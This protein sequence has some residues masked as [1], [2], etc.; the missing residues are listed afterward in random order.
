MSEKIVAELKSEAIDEYRAIPFWSWNDELEEKKLVK[1]IEWMK[2]AGFGGYFMHARGGLK[3]EYMGEKW[4]SCIKACVKAGKRLKMESW[5]YD[6]NGWPSGFAGGKLLENPDYRDRYLTRERGDFDETAYASYLITKD[7]LIRVKTRTEADNSEKNYPE[8]EGFLNV[9]LKISVST[10]DILNEKVVKKFIE[11]T[12][13]EYKKR[14]GND[15]GGRANSAEMCANSAEDTDNAAGEGLKGFFTDEPQY[16]LNGQPYT[17]VLEEYFKN[18][19]GE[20]IKDGLGLL[21][22]DK[23]GC[24]EFR[25]KFWGAMHEL[26]LNSYAKQVYEWCEQSGVELTGHYLEESSLFGQMMCCAGITSFYEYEHMVG[27]DWLGRRTDTPVTPRQASSVARQLGKKRVLGEI[28]AMCGWDVTP[29]EL[30]IITEWLFVYGVNVICQH[31]VPY[32]EHGQRKRDYPAHYSEYNPW[33]KKDFKSFNDYFARLGYLLGESEEIVSV[34]LFAPVSSM[35]FDYKQG[36]AKEHEAD[37]SYKELA[38]RLGK[39]NIPFHILDEKIMEGHGKVVGKKLVVGNC[40]YEFVILPKTFT[41]SENTAR[42]F[43]EFYAA[44][45]KILFAEGVPEYLRWEKHDYAMKSNTTFEEIAAA[46]PYAISDTTTEIA[47]TLRR[48]NDGKEFIFA[49]NIS[50]EKSYTIEY[51]GKFK[52][53]KRLNLETLEEKV[54]S[55]KLTLEAGESCVLFF[56]DEEPKEEKVKGKIIP[57]DGFEI[58]NSSENY[59]L[60]DKPR[61]SKDGK[62]YGE[63]TRY[64]GIFDELL[65]ARYNGELYL[66]Y[67]FKIKEMPKTIS[68]GFEEMN[69]KELFVNGEKLENANFDENEERFYADI[70]EKV[71]IGLN[72]A[73]LKINFF[74]SEKTYY[75]LFGEGV[76]ETLKNCIAYETTIEA[77]FLK[78]DFGVYSERG[79]KRGKEKNVLISDGDF[80]LGKR[81]TEITD[82]V[83]EGYP[84]FAGHMTFVKEFEWDGSDCVLRLDGRYQLSYLEINGKPVPKSY[85]GNLAD[86][87]QFVKKGVNEARITLYSS[88]RNLLGP[89]RLKNEEGSFLVGPFSWEQQGSWKN[90]KSFN[91]RESYSFVRFG[92]FGEEDNVENAE[93]APTA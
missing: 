29:K 14:L 7:E 87:T 40:E 38:L 68:F 93:D 28:Y 59:M 36:V 76:T 6:E 27:I 89:H 62:T 37:R 51:F 77:G 67:E 54:V 20:D 71:K 12:H 41:L 61:Y 30:K 18:N 9:Y 25:Y 78:G 1:Q 47:S 35:Y 57:D 4:F 11:L 63:K 91:E 22:E 84:F 39:A 23:S 17:L 33:V 73:V 66:K 72:E 92:L 85:F 42:L 49:A 3:T 8:N 83:K 86:I 45:G 90:G 81:K 16:Y 5:A 53:F 60:I 82:T 79:F 46:Q 48:T 26:M 80:Y 15:F 65:G 32:A 31:L 21:F 10:V 55:K 58:E 70:S 19:Y 56:S 2:S 69:V 64:M 52:S 24:R 75:A 34:G 44:G 74:E 43:E 88:N 50:F 13:E